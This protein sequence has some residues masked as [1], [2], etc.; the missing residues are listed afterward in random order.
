MEKRNIFS[1]LMEGVAAD[2]NAGA[3]VSGYVARLDEVAGG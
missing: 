1:E 2:R 3:A